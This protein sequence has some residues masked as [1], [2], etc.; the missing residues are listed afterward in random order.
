MNERQKLAMQIGRECRCIVPRPWSS[1]CVWCQRHIAPDEDRGF[2][3]LLGAVHV[4]CIVEAVAVADSY[5][6]ESS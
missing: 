1:T 3:P 4:D 6:A 5:L 2:I